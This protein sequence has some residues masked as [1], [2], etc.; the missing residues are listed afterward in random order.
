[1]SCETTTDWSL[2]SATRKRYHSFCA[3]RRGEVRISCGFTQARLLYSP[4]P[5]SI[6]AM[7]FNVTRSSKFHAV[8][9]LRWYRLTW[10]HFSHFYAS[11]YPLNSCQLSISRSRASRLIRG[12][13]SVFQKRNS[14]VSRADCSGHEHSEHYRRHP[15]AYSH[16][17]FAAV[18]RYCPQPQAYSQL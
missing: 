9:K 5:D 15:P 13:S 16:Y 12:S 7:I 11:R 4:L 2:R 17:L 10:I 18:A 14:P 6:Q 1:M 3:L 8:G